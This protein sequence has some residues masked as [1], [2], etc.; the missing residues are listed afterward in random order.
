MMG[1]VPALQAHRTDVIGALK[2]AGHGSASDRSPMRAALLVV[3]GALSVVLLVGAGLFIR[4][5]EHVRDVHF[6]FDVDRTV[7]AIVSPWQGKTLDPATQRVLAQRIVE[8]AKRIPGVT[9]AARASGG[10][11]VGTAGASLFI[12]GLGSVDHLTYFGAVAA[13]PEYFQTIGTRIVRGRGFTSEDAADNAPR[14]AVVSDTMARMLW[15]GQDAIGKRMQ[16]GSD[17]SAYTTVVGI[18]ENTIDNAISGKRPITYYVPIEQIWYDPG[19]VDVFIRTR[20]DARQYGPTIQRALQ[21]LVPGTAYLALRRMQE[22]L[23]PRVQP[24]KIGAV[25]F[26]AFGALAL[27]VAAVGLYSVIS[28][29]VARRTRELGIR[30]ALGAKTRHVLRAVATESALFAAVG[31]LLGG[32]IAF[33][34]GPHLAPLLFAESPRDPVVFAA[35]VATLAMAVLAATIGPVIRASHVDPGTALRTE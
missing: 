8:V 4:S 15:P 18:A 21:D 27:I 17:T 12:P 26:L 33:L 16:I 1:L 3:Q 35:V 22:V 25:L 14:V 5:L 11:L 31:V 10:P 7:E 9:N 32:A 24:W 30:I 19:A 20:G 29:D 34:A 13:S 28:Y 23:D 6:G 2:G